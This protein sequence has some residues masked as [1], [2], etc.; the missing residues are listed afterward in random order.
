MLFDGVVKLCIY[1]LEKDVLWLKV[2]LS[3][4]V[5]CDGCVLGIKVWVS[6]IV[7]GLEFMLLVIYL[8]EN[9]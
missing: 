9:W 6:Y 2:G 4:G 5:N 3:F 8:F 7:D 1:I